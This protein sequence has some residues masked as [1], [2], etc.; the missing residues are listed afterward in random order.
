LVAAVRLYLEQAGT[1]AGIDIAL[2]HRLL[3][4][5][6]A[7]TRLALYRIVQ[8]AVTN[9]RKHAE[10]RLASV[11]IEERE[12]GIL[13]RVTDDG[14][15]F[16]ASNGSPPGHLGLSAMREHA[17]IAGGR[18]SIRSRPRE[19]TTIEAWVPAGTGSHA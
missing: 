17:E 5:P 3:T 19:G 12:G 15:G 16:D 14:V 2:D 10:A 13:V 11:T 9:V 7:T 8:E 6:G 4:E 18:L 1:E